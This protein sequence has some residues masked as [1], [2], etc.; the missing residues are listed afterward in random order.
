MFYSLIWS[1]LTLFYILLAERYSEVL[2]EIPNPFAS[3]EETGLEKVPLLYQL[4]AGKTRESDPDILR[5]VN[6]VMVDWSRVYQKVR[7]KKGCECPFYEPSSTMTA[8]RS[9]FA[10]LT[11]TCGWV[12]CLDDLKGFDGCLDHVLTKQFDERQRKYVSF[13]SVLFYFF[14]VYLPSCPLL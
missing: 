7:P 1:A 13:I 8:F 3:K 2:K 6:R 14:T 12:I 9:L 4:V 10:Y 5:L 11:V